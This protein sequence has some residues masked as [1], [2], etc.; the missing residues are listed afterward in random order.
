MLGKKGSE[1]ENWKIT[2]KSPARL[3]EALPRADVVEFSG[4][5]Q[6]PSVF[7]KRCG[8]RGRAGAEINGRLSPV[9][10]GAFVN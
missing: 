7:C 10:A 6:K 4:A 9:C 8:T 1:E 5:I 3:P 2:G